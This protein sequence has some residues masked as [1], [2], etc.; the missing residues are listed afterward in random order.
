MDKGDEGMGGGGSTYDYGFRIY[1]AQLG[2]FLSVD[3]LTSKYAFYTPYQFAGNKPI[4]ALDLDGLEDIWVQNIVS[5]DGKTIL[6]TII[7]YDVNEHTRKILEQTTKQSISSTGLIV[8]VEGPNNQ[9]HV[10]QYTP[11]ITQVKP[12]K[13]ILDEIGDGMESFHTSLVGS[14]EAQESFINGVEGSGNVIKAF[15]VGACFINPLAGLAIYAIGETVTK[16]ADLMTTSVHLE[17]GETKEATIE[18]VSFAVGFGAGKITDLVKDEG[19]RIVT[20]TVVDVVIDK[21]K[22]AAKDAVKEEKK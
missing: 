5:N 22:D 14:D 1:N 19:K 20:Q 12:S 9:T 4:V 11:T 7:N 6:Q 8:T 15:G 2:R 16:G 10:V 3:P 18:A 13:S 17:K 21:T